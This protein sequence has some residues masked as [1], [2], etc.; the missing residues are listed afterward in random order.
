MKKIL[1]LIL[2]SSLLGCATDTYVLCASM[3]DPETDETQI[4]CEVSS[5]VKRSRF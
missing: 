4:S 2:L 3:T 5:D 1:L